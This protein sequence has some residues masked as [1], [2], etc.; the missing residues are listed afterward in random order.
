MPPGQ[1][2]KIELAVEHTEGLTGEVAKSASVS[3]NDPKNPNFNLILRARF[4]SDSPPGAPVTPGPLNPNPVLTVE[5][6]DRW[7]TSALTGSSSANTLYVYNPQPTPVRVES[8]IPGGTAFTAT[9][10]TIQ[11]G[12]RYQLSVTSNPSLKAGHYVQT[13][14]VVTDSAA[15][16]EVKI[17]LDLTVYPKVLA[18]PPSITMPTL[19]ITN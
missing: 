11:E 6:A 13:V 18:S 5:P 8:V 17:E 16:P 9:L 19:P 1:E 15:Q 3:T 2:G 10:S 12:K 4:K 7:I 14:R